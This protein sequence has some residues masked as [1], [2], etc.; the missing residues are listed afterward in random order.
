MKHIVINAHF[1]CE[2]LA[3]GVFDLCYVPTLHQ[4][5]DVFTKILPPSRFTVLCKKLNLCFSLKFNLSGDVR[6]SVKCLPID[7]G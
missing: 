2:K 6:H 4:V 1:V 5:A 7:H 3:V